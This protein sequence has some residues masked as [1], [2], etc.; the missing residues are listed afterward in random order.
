MGVIWVRVLSRSNIILQFPSLRK[1]MSEANEREDKQLLDILHAERHVQ[2]GVSSMHYINV[3]YTIWYFRKP[4]YASKSIRYKNK[5]FPISY[6][7]MISS[8]ILIFIHFIRSN[9]CIILGTVIKLCFLQRD[10]NST[11]IF[12][13]FTYSVFNLP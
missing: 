6:V 2:W 3:N 9:N 4:R 5:L 13:L 1:V 12:Y 7:R 8:K 11:R 10:A